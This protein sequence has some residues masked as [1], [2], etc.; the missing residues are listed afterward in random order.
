MTVRYETDGPIAI[1]TIDRLDVANAVDAETAMRL[2]DAFERF[3][4]DPDLSVAILTGTGGKFSA[5]GDLKAMM[6]G[7]GITVRPH[8]P[9][10]LGPTRVMLSKPVIAAGGGDAGARGVEVGALGGPRAAGPA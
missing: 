7:R 8:R 10:P 9:G 5:G 1:V 6:E 4:A 3:D 2:V